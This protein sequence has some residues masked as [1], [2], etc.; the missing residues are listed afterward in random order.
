M[1]DS[2]ETNLA[3][4]Q[5]L[6]NGTVGGEQPSSLIIF[7]PK[8]EAIL[9]RLSFNNQSTTSRLLNLNG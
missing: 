5:N 8:E 4:N 6:L 9:D 3:A 7:T 1:R 2:Q